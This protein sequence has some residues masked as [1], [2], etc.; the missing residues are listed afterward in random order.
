MTLSPNNPPKVASDKPLRTYVRTHTHTH[1]G[2][3]PASVRLDQTQSDSNQTESEA[4]H[5]GSVRVEEVNLLPLLLLLDQHLELQ[6]CYN[7]KKKQQKTKQNK[8]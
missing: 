1:T 4:E 6:L 2:H 8:T 5:I 3:A 7:A